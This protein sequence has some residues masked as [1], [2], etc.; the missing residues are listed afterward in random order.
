MGAEGTSK[1]GSG[2]APETPPGTSAPHLSLAQRQ[3]DALYQRDRRGQWR[4]VARVSDVEVYEQAKEI[5]FGE[6]N[7]SDDLLLPSEFAYQ[8]YVCLVRKVAWAS[9]VNREAPEKG[10]ILRGVTA[11]IL[12][13]VQQ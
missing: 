12:A 4:L 8:H 6:I 2:G 5:L 13:R 11:E 10:R 7:R 1:P 3:P 9:K